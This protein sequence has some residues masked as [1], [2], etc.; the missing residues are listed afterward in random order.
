MGH[1]RDHWPDARVTDVPGIGCL[2]LPVGGMGMDRRTRLA[3]I[4]TMTF[5]LTVGGVGPVVVSAADTPEGAVTDVLD[6]FGAKDF[7]N[8]GPLVC[9]ARRDEIVGQLDMTAAFAGLGI[10]P[11][12]ILDAMTIAFEDPQVTLV[13]QD[14]A[15]AIVHLATTMSMTITLDEETIR[16]IVVGVLE[17]SG[18]EVTDQTVEEY[19]GILGASLNQSMS[20]EADTDVEVV[21]ENGEWLMCDTLDDAEPSASPLPAA[22][23][24]T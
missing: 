17:A 14:E 21:N 18:M 10:E 12:V 22:T 9:E 5:L 3:V 19:V 7:G 2:V 23:P 16:T 4:V 13:S 1:S 8:L 15:S 11:Q 20:E 6:A 24:A